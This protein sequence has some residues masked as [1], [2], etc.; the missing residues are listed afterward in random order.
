MKINKKFGVA[1]AVLLGIVVTAGG[2]AAYGETNENLPLNREETEIEDNS[3]E[4]LT[5]EGVVAGRIDSHSVKIEVDGEL[6][7]FGIS[8]ELRDQEFHAGEITFKYYLDENERN[9]IIEAELE[10]PERGE[11]HT[12][13]GIFTGLADRHTAELKIDGEYRAYGLAKNIDFNGIDVGEILW[14]V[15]QENENGREEIVKIEIIN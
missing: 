12:A 13:E 1:L 2:I 7:V 4:I 5:G 15:Y 8:D 11:K 3:P 6:K 9:I 14:I 10:E